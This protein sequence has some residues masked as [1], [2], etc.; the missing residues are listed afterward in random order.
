MCRESWGAAHFQGRIIQIPSLLIRNYL[1]SCA[2]VFILTD[3]KSRNQCKRLSVLC[4]A[5]EIPALE[6][7]T[8]FV[9]SVE[10]LFHNN[11]HGEYSHKRNSQTKAAVS[12]SVISV[13]SSRIY[14]YT[15]SSGGGNADETVYFLSADGKLPIHI[16]TRHLSSFIPLTPL[17]GKPTVVLK[18]GD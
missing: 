14:L 3:V 2:L 15:S 5:F 6:I 1:Y 10:I 11:H 8:G 9:C 7:W 12:L 18:K 17:L 16:H 13:V 4:L